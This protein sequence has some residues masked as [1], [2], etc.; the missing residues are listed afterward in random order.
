M[1]LRYNFQAPGIS[2]RESGSS[3]AESSQEQQSPPPDL[4]HEEVRFSF[5]TSKAPCILLYVSSLTTDFLAVLV[6]PTG[7]DCDAWPLSVGWM[8][9]SSESLDHSWL[10][11]YSSQEVEQVT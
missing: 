8:E 4:T 10:L 11:L 3:R 7:K 2:S 1:W 6:Q 5:S 9:C